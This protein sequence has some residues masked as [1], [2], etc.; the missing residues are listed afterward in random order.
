MSRTQFLS[1]IALNAVLLAV[2]ALVSMSGSA[3]AQQT[4]QRGSYMLISSG[5]TGTPLSV[6]YV[7]DETNSELVALAWD[8]T[9]K[10]MNYVGYRNIAADSMQARRSGR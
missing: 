7:I 1:L 2:L 6:V 8:D 3:S 5:V 4:R 10:K 9:V